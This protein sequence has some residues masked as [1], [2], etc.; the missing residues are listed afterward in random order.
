MIPYPTR[1]YPQKFRFQLGEFLISQLRLQ[2]FDLFWI[3]SACMAILETEHVDVNYLVDLRLIRKK[4]RL[5][6]QRIDTIE[7]IV[8][9]RP[10]NFVTRKQ[11]Q[12]RIFITLNHP[13]PLVL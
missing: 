13:E 10:T 8:N 3:N 4:G 2:T 1:K 11:D 9:N 6:Q 12:A 5:I 7:D